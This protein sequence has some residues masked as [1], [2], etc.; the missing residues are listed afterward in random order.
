VCRLQGAR[1]A[2]EGERSALGNT[3]I[4]IK[5]ENLAWRTRKIN[6]VTSSNSGSWG[7]MDRDPHPQGGDVI[8]SRL[9]IWAIAQSNSDYPTTIPRCTIEVHYD[10]EMQNF[11]ESELSRY[12]ST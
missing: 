12:S 8:L 5:G 6:R 1:V 10:W 7:G 9:Q 3:G 11:M 4:V 2:I